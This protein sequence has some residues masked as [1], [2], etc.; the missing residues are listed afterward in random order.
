MSQ[1]TSS[2]LSGTCVGR[3][4]LVYNDGPTDQTPASG[5]GGSLTGVV[6]SAGWADLGGAYPAATWYKDMDGYIRLTGL[7]KRTGTT[8]S[9]GYS[10][11]IFTLPVGARP[12]GTEQF[13]VAKDATVAFCEVGADGVC[14]FWVPY[15]WTSE[16]SSMCLSGMMF[17]A[18]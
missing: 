3:K 15:T 18:A 1:A 13:M 8:I 14:Q 6:Y 16:V 5:G 17:R 4:I 11:A 7:L 10:G 2:G 12:A 9:A